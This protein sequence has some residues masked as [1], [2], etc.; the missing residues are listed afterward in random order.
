MFLFNKKKK[1]EVQSR[2]KAELIT[3]HKEKKVP[4]KRYD[5]VLKRGDNGKKVK[6]LQYALGGLLMDGDFGE[7]TELKVK[8]MNH[9][10]TV[11]SQEYDRLMSKLEDKP[12]IKLARSYVGQIEEQDVTGDGKADNR[13][14]EIDKMTK[15]VFEWYNPTKNTVGYAWCAIFVSY[16]LHTA[17]ENWSFKDAS[18]AKWMEWMENFAGCEEMKNSR[19]LSKDKVYIGAWVNSNGYGH[20]FFVDPYKTCLEDDPKIICTIEGNTNDG[21]SRE[22][23]GVYERE[24]W[25]TDSG[26]IRVFGIKR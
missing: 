13:S 25:F 8:M 23:T 6:L 12:H 14:P 9:R 11:N 7:K 3:D 20:I 2:E 10:G 17:Y 16:V 4:E 15:Y 5:F 21:G 1:Q 26:K 22:G 24:R 18:V 19:Y